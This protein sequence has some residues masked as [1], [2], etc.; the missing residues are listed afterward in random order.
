VGAGF[1]DEFADDQPFSDFLRWLARRPGSRRVFLGDT[2]DFLRV[3][4][5]GTRT[6]LFARCGDPLDLQLRHKVLQVAADRV[7]GQAHAFR[8]LTAAD[9]IGQVRQHLPLP[10][11]ERRHRVISRGG[12]LWALVKEQPQDRADRN[13]WQPH[14]V[15]HHAPDSRQQMLDRVFLPHPSGDTGPKGLHDAPGLR[16]FSQHDHPD[17]VPGRPAGAGHLRGESHSVSQ[18]G[19]QQRDIDVAADQQPTRRGHRLDG[20]QH[21]Q[22]G[23][24]REPASESVGERAL[25][26]DHYH[27]DLSHTTSVPSLPALGYRGCAWASTTYGGE[28][29]R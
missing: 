13:G 5:T 18:L 15:A 11:G 27:A 19:I 20:G 17:R 6:G 28:P 21:P 14:F 23:L 9:P 22:A 7:G 4:V 29:S 12:P 3:P 24:C 8:Y 1:S 16:H 10:G 2:F 26:V 25:A